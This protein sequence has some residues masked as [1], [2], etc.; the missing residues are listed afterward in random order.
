MQIAL[1]KMIYRYPFSTFAGAT[2]S[3]ASGGIGYRQSMVSVLAIINR[4]WRCGWSITGY[5]CSP[6]NPPLRYVPQNK[7]LSFAGSTV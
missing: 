4:P 2:A 5:L 7:S 1:E 6:T 3:P